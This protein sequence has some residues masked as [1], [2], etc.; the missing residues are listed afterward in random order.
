MSVIETERLTKSYG[1]AR[2][3]EDVTISVEKGEVFGCLGPNGAGKTTLIRTLLDLLHPTSGTRPDIRPGQSPRQRRHSPEAWQFARRLRLRLRCDWPRGAGSPCSSQ[4]HAG[5]WACRGPRKALSSGPGSAPWASIPGEPTEG[6]ADLGGVSF[7]GTADPRRADE[8]PRSPDAKRVSRA[9]QGR[10][11][12][13]VRRLH[14][15]A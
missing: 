5:P 12:T 4:G 13:R 8:R 10:A 1:S 7:A 15:L 14:L 6:R 11:G 9:D 3:I 2:G